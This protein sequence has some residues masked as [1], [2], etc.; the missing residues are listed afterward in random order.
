MGKEIKKDT[1]FLIISVLL[2][3]IVLLET[4]YSSFFAV[5]SRTS[6]QSINTGT[7]NV[8]I[9][10]TSTTM[11]NQTLFPTS[12][13]DMP[14]ASNSVVSNTFQ[15]ATLVLENLGT[16]EAD[17]SVTIGYDELPSGKT[18][19]DLISMQY[20]YIGIYDINNNEWVN[21]GTNENPTYYTLITGLVPSDT[22]IYPII[23]NTIVSNGVKQYKIY[24]WL[25]ENTPITEIDKLVYLKVEVKSTTINGRVEE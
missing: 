4:S 18:I 25:S 10:N 20:L 19:N 5:Q 15:Y 14:T 13:D 24:I 8:T 11:N 22:N 1:I 3:T 6:V 2:L 7:L 16:I 21:F 12:T 23:R 17:Y 9:D